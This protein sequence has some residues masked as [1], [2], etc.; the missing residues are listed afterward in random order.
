MTERELDEIMIL[1]WPGVLRRA[2]VEGDP[3]VQGFV[4]SIAR[5]YKRRDWMP[6]PKQEFFMRA[7][8]RELRGQD[9]AHPELIEE[10][11]SDTDA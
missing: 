8:L 10:E 3:W 6:S 11:G 5:A 2:M 1:H 4:R 7:C 9:D